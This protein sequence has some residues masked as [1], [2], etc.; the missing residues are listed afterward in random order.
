MFG[1]GKKK[2]SSVLVAAASGTV[3]NV[4][5]LPDEVFSKKILGDGYA[6]KPMNGTIVSPADGKIIDVQD[7]HHAYGILTNDGLEL[8]VHI[9]IDT[10]SLNGEGFT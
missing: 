8:L 3:V 5:T 1:F 10:V 2:N 6:V 7:S 9:G 4:E